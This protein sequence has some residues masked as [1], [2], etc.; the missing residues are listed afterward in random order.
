MRVELLVEGYTDEV[1]V[2]RAYG[3]LGIEV[4]TVYGKRGV[5]Y[6]IER[7]AGFA[8]RGEFAPILILADSMDVPSICPR[9]AVRTLV[10]ALSAR[11]LVRLAERE[12]ESWLLASRMELARYFGVSMAQIPENPDQVVDPKQ[13]LV[14]IARRSPRG[15][16][17][18]MFVPKERSSALVGEGYV[19]GFSEFMSDHW[20][21]GSA[22]ASSPSFSKFVLRSRE[23][24][25]G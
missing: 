12:T 2:R 25:L 3:D 6:V 15:R 17:R 14:N 21:S 11:A 10:P 4:G 7:A 8:A 5:S 16:I 23:L 19:D 20:D 18:Q 9:E 24:F 13:A 1:F 22:A